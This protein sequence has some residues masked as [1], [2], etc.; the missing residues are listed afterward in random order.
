MITTPKIEHRPEQA[1]AAIR[2]AVPIPFGKYLAPLWGEVNQWL[3]KKGINQ[4]GAAIIKY[5]TTDMSTKLDIEVGFFFDGQLIGDERVIVSSMTAG[6]YVTLL[7]TGPYRGKG[8]YKATVAL[9]E[10]TEKN[11]VNWDLKK[12]DNVETWNNRFEIYL[13]DH[14]KETDTKKYQTELA[15]GIK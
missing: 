6:D 2:T 14:A 10:W 8:I 12:Q 9:F 11:P 4:T 13:T 7:Y 1:Y 15:F 5:L 3:A